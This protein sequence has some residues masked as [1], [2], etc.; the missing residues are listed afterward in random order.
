MARLRD[1]RLIL[2]FSKSVIIVSLKVAAAFFAF[3]LNVLIARHFGSDGLGLFYIAV[4]IA[5]VSSNFSR[6]GLEQAVLKKGACLFKEKRFSKL[7]GIVSVGL[8]KIFI[9]SVL[10]SVILS[11]NS[12]YIN[13]VLGDNG[14][15]E[16]LYYMSFMVPLIALNVYFS[17][18]NK[19]IGFPAFSVFFLSAFLPLSSAFMLYCL[20][21][22][23]FLQFTQIYVC[24][25]LL[26]VLINSTCWIKIL[27]FG[28]EFDLKEI[29]ANAIFAL[30][31]WWVAIL[32]HL[33][34]WLPALILG[35]FL[36]P[37]DVGLFS[38]AQKISLF[39]SFILVAVNSLDTPK[40]AT[41]K[42]AEDIKQVAAHSFKVLLYLTLP[43]SIIIISFSETIL[44]LFGEEFK[45]A[46]V[47]LVIL[48]F[49]Q[50]VNVMTGSVGVIL[51]MTGNGE[52]LLRNVFVSLVICIVI[53]F[54]L[55][56]S[57]GIVGAS[58]ACSCAI[59]LQNIIGLFDVRRM[60]K[61][62]SLN[63]KGVKG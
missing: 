28:V 55:I 6:L 63:L 5:L 35:Y 58:V 62:E 30:P 60:L 21:G 37:H 42:S 49:G 27:R 53:S 25:A 12:E 7:N 23:S 56:P 24:C 45:E 47:A 1:S 44:F 48:V 59:S 31:L 17:Q 57:Y 40:Y 43:L 33:M 11:F 18:L 16:A 2:Y 50:V 52:Y 38:A 36:S 15:E 4:T 3:L 8:L 26:G 22:I 54:A 41:A 19:A 46:K 10:M 34:L 32:N 14:S 51:S 39:V 13:S 61:K 9:V 29:A 20:E